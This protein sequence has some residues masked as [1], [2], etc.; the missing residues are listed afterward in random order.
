MMICFHGEVV[1]PDKTLPDAF[2]L[3]DSGRILEV[4][5]TRPADVAVIEG[6]YIAPG[7]IDMHVHGAMGPTIWTAARKPCASANRAHARHGTTTI[8]PTTTTGTTEEIGAMLQACADVRD[9][10]S[11]AEGSCI[12]GVHYYGPYFAADKVGCHAAEGRRDPDAAEYERFLS[13]GPDPIAT[14]AAELPGAAEFYA[15]T[16]PRIVW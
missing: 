14:C 11:V 1:L 5:Q 4:G 3:C 8:F 12:G 2:V 7:F 9:R 10:W 15:R 13:L 16:A 6:R